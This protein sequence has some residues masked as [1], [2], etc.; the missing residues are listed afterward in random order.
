MY[1]KLHHISTYIQKMYKMYKTCTKFSPKKAWNLKCMFFAHTNTNYTKFIQPANWSSFCMFFVHTNNV[2]TI[3]TLYNK[4]TET[5]FTC[6]LYIQTKYKLYKIYTNVNQ[7][8]YAAT[9][10]FFLYKKPLHPLLFEYFH[11]NSER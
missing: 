6:S 11:I 1:K 4:L 8:I 2:Q 5:T 10:V 7:I 9:D 3:Q